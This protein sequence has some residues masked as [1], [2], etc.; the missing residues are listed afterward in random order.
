M[1]LLD[2]KFLSNAKKNRLER[3][4]EGVNYVFRNSGICIALWRDFFSMCKNQRRFEG[5]NYEIQNI[6]FC[7]SAADNGTNKPNRNRNRHERNPDKVNVN[8]RFN[9][10]GNRDVT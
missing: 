1:I 6:G 4:F 3:R 10:F 2:E 7:K 5:S 8:A 9:H